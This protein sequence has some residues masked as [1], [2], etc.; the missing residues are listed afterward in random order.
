M[1]DVLIYS[2]ETDGSMLPMHWYCKV[3]QSGRVIYGK[4]YRFDDK[5]VFKKEIVL[6]KD[7][8]KKIEAIIDRHSQ[9]FSVKSVEGSDVCLVLDGSTQT[10]SF[11]D[12]QRKNSL[13]VDDL[14]MW[15]KNDLS[16]MPNMQ[17]LIALRN[18]IQKILI[19]AGID[20]E[21]C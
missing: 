7:E 10:I 8:I 4:Q 15:E 12:G 16:K 18:D 13:K 3:Y 9:L 20:D 11:S 17:S 1:A 19:N 14:W 5:P 2:Y 6:A 21:Y